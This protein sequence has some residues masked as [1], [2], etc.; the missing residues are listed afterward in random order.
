MYCVWERVSWILETRGKTLTFGLSIPEAS[1]L[2]STSA[3][4][5][6]GDRMK[7]DSGSVDE[8][9]SSPG[10]GRVSIVIESSSRLDFLK[11]WFVSSL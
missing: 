1:L 2:T 6:T 8:E 9:D 7:C 3:W 11:T 10:L 5:L 4:P